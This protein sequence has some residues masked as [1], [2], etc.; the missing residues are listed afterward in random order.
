MGHT[1]PAA[2]VAALLSTHAW[3]MWQLTRE[4]WSVDSA[5]PEW[6]AVDPFQDG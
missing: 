1:V 3:L 4:H 5:L 2:L 6:R